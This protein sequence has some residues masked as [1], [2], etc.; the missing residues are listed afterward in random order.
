MLK[1]QNLYGCIL[2]SGQPT[3]LY[4]YFEEKEYLSQMWNVKKGVVNFEFY[5]ITLIHLYPI[6]YRIL[7][8]K[9]C[10]SFYEIT[11]SY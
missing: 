4:L 10:N 9:R 5:V 1:S 3:L 8:S 6:Q 11:N 2:I 7:F